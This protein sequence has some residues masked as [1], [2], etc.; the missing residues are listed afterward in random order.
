MDDVASQSFWSVFDP[1]DCFRVPLLYLWPLVLDLRV[2]VA[3]GFFMSGG[4]KFVPIPDY[5]GF[6]RCR[7]FI[8]GSA[9]HEISSTC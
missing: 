5:C 3:L 6:I 9:Q 1:F 8:S 2:V 7:V 4:S